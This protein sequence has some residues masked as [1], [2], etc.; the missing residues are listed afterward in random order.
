VGLFTSSK[1]KI[2]D[3]RTPETKAA[4]TW[5]LNTLRSPTPDFPTQDIAQLTPAEQ[6]A[7]DLVGGYARS[8]P[9]GLD[10]LRGM[11]TATGGGMTPELQGLIDEVMEK[12]Q[13]ETNR[14]GRKVQI[15]GAARTSA[16]RDVLGR[17][18]QDTE[19]NIMN[20]ALPYLTQAKENAE[21]RK[22]TA[23]QA[24]ATLGESSMLNRINALSTT[25][26]L[27]RIIEQL[28]KDA[29]YAKAMQ[30]INFPY[31]QQAGIAGML[32]NAPAQTAVTGGEPSLFSQ[33]S[34]AIGMLGGL[35]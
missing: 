26:A 24:L 2:K 27:P 9:E 22:L 10:V 20:V 16:G 17:S 4:A 35:F 1:K 8:S 15:A 32:L 31:Q 28:Q 30:Q 11:T 3:V 21:N 34:P 19:R 12:G 14:M 33:L 7:Q 18:V 5:A 6:Q 29:E 23:A 13:Q 25:G